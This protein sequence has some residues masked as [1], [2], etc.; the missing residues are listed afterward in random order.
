MDL[1]SVIIPGNAPNLLPC[2]PADKIDSTSHQLVVQ[3]HSKNVIPG[4][5][6]ASKKTVRSGGIARGSAPHTTR[7]EQ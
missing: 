7:D 2:A 1:A 5:S 3:V 6:N 4:V